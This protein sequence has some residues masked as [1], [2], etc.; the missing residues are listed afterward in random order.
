MRRVL[1]GRRKNNDTVN[2]GVCFLANADLRIRPFHIG[3]PEKL[4]ES[5][6]VPVCHH[7]TGM[8]LIFFLII[9]FDA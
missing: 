9:K 4:T 2:N 1:V 5:L 3:R 7:K 8:L 6:Q